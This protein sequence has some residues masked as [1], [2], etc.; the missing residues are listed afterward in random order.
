MFIIS[1][2]GLVTV[3]KTFFETELRRSGAGG[4]LEISYV[5]LDGRKAHFVENFA[6]AVLFYK[7]ERLVYAHRVEIVCKVGIEMLVEKT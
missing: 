7:V 5:L 3:F 1:N 2:G 4:T 6:R